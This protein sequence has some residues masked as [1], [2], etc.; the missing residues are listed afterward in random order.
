[1]EKQITPKDVNKKYIEEESQ[2][3]SE[4]LLKAIKKSNSL[5]LSRYKKLVSNGSTSFSPRTLGW[6]NIDKR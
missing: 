6:T 3:I 4:M 5:L 2:I 1:M